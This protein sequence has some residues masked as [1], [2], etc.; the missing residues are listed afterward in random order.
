MDHLESML[1]DAVKR[2]SSTEAIQALIDEQIGK[3]I[4]ATIKNAM[5]SY[6]DLNKQIE[7]KMKAALVLPDLDLPSYGHMVMARL[8]S[9]MDDTLN[10]LM[11]ATIE[12][13]VQ[14][15]F[16]LAPKV[17]ELEKVIEALRENA[18]SNEESSR[19]SFETDDTGG[20]NSFW[21]GMDPAE[22][23]KRHDC[24][25]R[26]LVSPIVYRTRDMPEIDF[27][28]DQF[29]IAALYIDRS[30]AVKVQHFGHMTTWK[31][32]LFT[33]YCCKTPVILGDLE[34]RLDTYDD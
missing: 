9:A 18:R 2:H 10:D 3:V 15:L 25:I 12:K 17:L 26:M 30:D 19:I 22:G 5:Q 16:E 28:K 33:A 13:E 29:K 6:G 7:A 1:I 8:R 20:Y 24:E 4:A 27:Y 21:I 34:P 11:K 23:T 32:M 31:K 14:E